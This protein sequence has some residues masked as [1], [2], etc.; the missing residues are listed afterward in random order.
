MRPNIWAQSLRRHELDPALQDILQKE[1]QSH[2]IVEGLLLRPEPHEE[3]DVAL[4]ALLPAN[5]RAEEAEP[6]DSKGVDLFPVRL[7]PVEDL[8]L[9]RD[10][11][12]GGYLTRGFS[13]F[14]AST[15]HTLMR[16][17]DTLSRI[18]E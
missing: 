15:G 6:F 14:A 17:S 1:R 18:L 2:K 11:R 3:I 9:C 10:G 7:N 12:H 16:R 8:L 4:R 13:Y 5:E